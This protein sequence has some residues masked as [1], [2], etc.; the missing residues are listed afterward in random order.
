M[1]CTDFC[2]AHYIIAALFGVLVGSVANWR[3]YETLMRVAGEPAAARPKGVRRLGRLRLHGSYWF[4]RMRK[5]SARV[6]HA[7][8]VGAVGKPDPVCS[9]MRFAEGG[10]GSWMKK[11]AALEMGNALLFALSFHLFGWTLKGIVVMGL[12]TVFLAI[13]FID[14]EERI[15]PDGITLTGLAVGLMVGPR[16]FGIGIVESI[17]GVLLGGGLFYIIAMVSRGGM[18]GGDI[19]FMAMTG[20]FVGWKGALITIFIGSTLGAAIGIGLMVLRGFHRKTPIP[21]GPFLALGALVSIMYGSELASW[22]LSTT[23]L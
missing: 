17:M 10:A 23:M 11:Y 14:L 3:V 21:F 1:T 19:K 16:V 22:Y 8:A 4:Y 6:A 5:G 20:A 9:L 18:G 13:A 15:I 12:V 2:I 7:S